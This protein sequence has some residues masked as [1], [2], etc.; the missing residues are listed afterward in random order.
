MAKLLRFHQGGQF[1]V[2]T[3][4]GNKENYSIKATLTLLMMAGIMLKS[5]E[6]KSSK[7]QQVRMVMF[8]VLP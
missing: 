1:T 4:E 8:Q 3:A 7:L 2:E 6:E 5:V